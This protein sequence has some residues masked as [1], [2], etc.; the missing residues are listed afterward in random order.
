VR[1]HPIDDQ[2]SPSTWPDPALPGGAAG[3]T[4]RPPDG[5]DLRTVAAAVSAVPPTAPPA[6]DGGGG[7]QCLPEPSGDRGGGERLHPEPGPGSSAVSVPHGA[8]W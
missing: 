4:L 6:P 1:R 2:P 5:E 8:G 7:D 3:Q